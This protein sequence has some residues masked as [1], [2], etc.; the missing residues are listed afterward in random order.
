LFHRFHWKS[1]SPALCIYKVTWWIVPISGC[2]QKKARTG[3][4]KDIF[5]L[6]SSHNYGW[7][8]GSAGGLSYK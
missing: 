6:F 7:H 5:T 8:V 1:I 2:Q 4:A 3:Q